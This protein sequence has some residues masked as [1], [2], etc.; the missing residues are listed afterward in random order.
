M[1]LEGS[2]LTV[3]LSLEGDQLEQ[4]DTSNGQ[5]GIYDCSR[6][7]TIVLEPDDST[8]ESPSHAPTE[9]ASA[10]PTVASTNSQSSQPSATT[11]TA[12]SDPVTAAPSDPLTAAPSDSPLPLSYL[13]E[14]LEDTGYQYGRCEGDCD[15]SGDCD[16]GLNCFD[17]DGFDAV[18]GCTSGGTGDVSGKDYVSK[19]YFRPAFA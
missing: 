6:N 3:R 12:P 9:T 18:P 19:H 13:G 4:L 1:P 16:W 8:S 5:Y 17:R 10:A 15:S 7:E 11:S 14:N 2:G